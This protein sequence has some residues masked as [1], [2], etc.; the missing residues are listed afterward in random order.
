MVHGRVDGRFTAHHPDPSAPENLA[1]L[2]SL[3]GE[4][5]DLGVAFDGDGDRIG[6]VPADGAILWPD[7]LI[8]LLAQDLVADR[9]GAAVAA[10][11]KSSRVL[12]DG[13]AV[14][15]ARAAMAPSGY[16]R[17]RDAMLAERAPLAGEIS[18]HVFFADRWRGSDHALHVAVRLL[19]AVA[20]RGDLTAWAGRLPRTHATPELRPPCANADKARVMAAIAA[21]LGLQGA[22]VDRTDGL[23]ATR[24]DGWWLLRE[25]GAEPKLT[26][27]V[28]AWDAAGRE[29]LR[30]SWSG[31]WRWRGWGEGGGRKC[32]SAA[33]V[34]S[35]FR[36]P[37]HE[38]SISVSLL[39]ACRRRLDLIG[40]LR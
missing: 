1:D 13:V 22:A 27:R 7:Q 31:C 38:I 12:F 9:P 21:A 3:V 8:L 36:T 18:G 5:L 20:R 15:G 29:R 34:A 39:S 25:S 26:V 14:A 2:Q 10:D 30:G 16:V 23:R 35:I 19:G 6:V 28:E 40:Q 37:P 33:I 4:G 24:P 32:R 11:V 17:V